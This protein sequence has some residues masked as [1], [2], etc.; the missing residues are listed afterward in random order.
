MNKKELV[1]QVRDDTH[2]SV[3]KVKKVLNSAI[4]IMSQCMLD[5]EPITIRDFGAFD[6]MERKARRGID[7]YNGGKSIQIPPTRV[8]KF[9]EAKPLHKKLNK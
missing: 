9:K 5:D 2:L 7:F 4:K 3:E 8:V 1:L 6:V